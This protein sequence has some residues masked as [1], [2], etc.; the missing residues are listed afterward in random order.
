MLGMS[1][2]SEMTG[3]IC[4]FAGTYAPLGY[5]DCDGKLLSMHDYPALYAIIGTTY[6]GDGKTNFALPDLRPFN[7][8]GQPDTGRNRRVDWSTLGMPRQVICIAGY[9]PS[10]P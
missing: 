3:S 2:D 5:S 10:R 4:T 9:W 7:K 1:I 8:D 6:G